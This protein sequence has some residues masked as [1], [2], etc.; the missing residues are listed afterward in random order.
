M[1]AIHQVPAEIW[2]LILISAILQPL[3]PS[4]DDSLLANIRLFNNDSEVLLEA[5]RT[6]SQLRLVCSTWDEI[7]KRY[8]LNSVY[9]R[10]KQPSLIP[11]SVV[12]VDIGDKGTFDSQL[13]QSLFS[14]WDTDPRERHAPIDYPAVEALVLTDIREDHAHIDLFPNL[15]L[16]STPYFQPD[17]VLSMFPTLLLNLTHLQV[18][19]I[20]A[21]KGV[22]GHLAFPRLHT[23]IINFCAPY[24]NRARPPNWEYQRAHVDCLNWS[25]PS[26]VNLGLRNGGHEIEDLLEKFG[27]VLK[28]I[29]LTIDS[30][31][32][33]NPT[34]AS[35]VSKIW[36]YCP[37]LSELHT[38]LTALTALSRPPL[39][40][41]PIRLIISDLH[42]PGSRKNGFGCRRL[43]HHD[44]SLFAYLASSWRLGSLEMDTSWSI[45]QK[46][47]KDFTDDSL[48]LIFNFFDQISQDGLDLKDRHGEGLDSA[49]AHAFMASLRQKEDLAEEPEAEFTDNEEDSASSIEDGSIENLGVVDYSYFM[50]RDYLD[51]LGAHD[52]D[53]NDGDYVP[54]DE[55]L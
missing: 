12:R 50:E 21:Y 46:R 23:L 40:R 14:P 15:R 45:L 7:L 25:L 47:L 1:K 38:V 10:G 30:K 8:P 42:Q 48:E 52:D 53:D 27:T 13:P 2:T 22:E 20:L 54:D 37:N 9:W 35:L 43:Y 17:S 26:L 49:S 39:M 24:L 3:L 34:D 29:S 36:S 31:R 5:H 32:Y 16:L 51:H 19:P 55:A 4:S 33:W 6:H 11:F 44:T 18:P 41:T 28:G